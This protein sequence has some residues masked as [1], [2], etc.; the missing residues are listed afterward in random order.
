[1]KNLAI[2][3][4]ITLV[5]GFNHSA[6]AQTNSSITK[7][8]A[9]GAPTSQP[10]STQTSQVQ[11]P[12]TAIVKVKS[13]PKKIGFRLKE[14]KTIHAPSAED[15][16]VTV[17]TLKKIGCEV[18]SGDHGNHIDVK[19]RCPDWKSMKVA[20]DQLVNQWTTWCAGKGMETIVVDPPATTQKPTITFRL[21]VERKVHLHD[22]VQSKQILNT[23]QLIGC[24]VTSNQH[25]DHMDATFSCPNWVT[26]EVRSKVNADAWQTWLDE[27]GFEMQQK[28]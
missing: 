24:K 27:S 5:I 6:T 11:Q 1:M 12:P 26:I 14:W 9:V 7:E 18:E 10:G 8:A 22:K 23:L 16:Q 20:T 28:R 4:A 21:P 17:A 15:A 13:A 19:Y 3:T 25:G 2:L